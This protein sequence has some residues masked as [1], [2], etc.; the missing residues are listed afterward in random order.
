[1]RVTRRY[2][3]AASHRLHSPQLSEEQNRETYGKCNNPYGHGHDYILEVTLRGPADR[4]TGLVMNREDF[5]GFVDRTVLRE[6]RHS[7]LNTQI[8]IFAASVPTTEN[9]AMEI[10]RRLADQWREAFP[11]SGPRLEK[12]RLYETRKNIIEVSGQ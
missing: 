7:N 2:R 9:V 6:L 10:R 4:Q 5:D 12:I 8:P 11:A 1:M 3:F